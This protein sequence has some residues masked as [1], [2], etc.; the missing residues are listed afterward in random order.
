MEQFPFQT[1]IFF[2]A[3]VDG[4]KYPGQTVVGGATKDEYNDNLG[5]FFN[6]LA[7]TQDDEGNP[8]FVTFEPREL[9][10]VRAAG[11][12]APLPDAPKTVPNCPIH[13]VPLKEKTVR[14][15]GAKFFSCGER[16][17]DGNYCNWK[18]QEQK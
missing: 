3:V 1:T 7:A 15:T 18:P 16:K 12:G 10:A 8:A 17:A 14:A 13:Q 2:Y 9:T 4:K 11:P 5:E 6:T